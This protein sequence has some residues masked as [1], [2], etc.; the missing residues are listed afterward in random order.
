MGKSNKMDK[1]ELV[2]RQVDDIVIYEPKLKMVRLLYHGH[3]YDA[4]I[5]GIGNE[6]I[7]RPDMYT[8]LWSCD[9]NIHHV[10][11]DAPFM[12]EKNTTY[13]RYTSVIML[14]PKSLGINASINGPMTAPVTI[15]A[16]AQMSQAK[17]NTNFIGSYDDDGNAHGIFI[18][19]SKK[20]MTFSSGGG[21][22]TLGPGGILLE[23]DLIQINGKV[24][25]HIPF[26]KNELSFIPST[27]VTPFAVTLAPDLDMLDKMKERIK[28][29]LDMVSVV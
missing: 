20:T 2:Q 8:G 16:P 5:A 22:I 6:S 14:Y 4:T 10:S 7:P 21:Q 24:K 11:L 23:G 13:R 29:L 3:F 15:G 9:K 18:D 28:P 27:V 17:G 26:K 1:A 12:D 19:M 25:Y